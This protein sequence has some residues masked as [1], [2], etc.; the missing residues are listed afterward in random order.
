MPLAGALALAAAVIPAGQ[1]SAENV[2]CRPSGS[3]VICTFSYTGGAQGWRVPAGVTSVTFAAYGAA[4]TAAGSAG[5]LG[6]EARATFAVR[7]GAP[8]EIVVGGTAGFNGG[9][10]GG[11]VTVGQAGG[12]GGGASDV[13]MGNCAYRGNCGL[14]FRDLIGAGGGGGGGGGAGG[15]GGGG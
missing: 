11:A 13:R 5:G 14:S 6:A 3:Q 9:G 15:G 10:S 4:G 12:S 7:P 1:A 8:V 2:S